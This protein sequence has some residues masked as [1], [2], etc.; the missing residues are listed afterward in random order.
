M[1]Q[2][3]FVVR[4]LRAGPYNLVHAYHVDQVEPAREDGTVSF[5]IPAGDNLDYAT[6]VAYLKAKYDI[7]VDFSKARVTGPDAKGRTLRTALA[8][9]GSSV[10]VDDMPRVLAG[11][12]VPDRSTS[13]FI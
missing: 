10:T 11:I 9:D 6:I 4:E 2:F 13:E 8:T 3:T 12:S 7:V 5:P 1:Q